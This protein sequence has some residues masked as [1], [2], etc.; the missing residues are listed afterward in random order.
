MGK[1]TK[2]KQVTSHVNQLLPLHNKIVR[3]TICIFKRLSLS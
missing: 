1:I 2:F 3:V